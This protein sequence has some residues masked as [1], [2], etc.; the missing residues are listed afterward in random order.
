MKIVLLLFLMLISAIVLYS[1]TAIVSSGDAFLRGKPSETGEVVDTLARDAKVQIITK[2]GPWYLVQ[3]SPF[4]GWVHRSSLR[5]L[6]ST[7]KPAQIIRQKSKSGPAAQTPIVAASSSPQ[8][9]VTPSPPAETS[10][11]SS[12]TKTA[13]VTG[14]ANDGRVYIRG[15]LGGCYFMRSGGKKVY[16]DRGFCN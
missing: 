14:P 12:A 5:F 9:V 4:V 8:P 16:V 11:T 15:K 2:K 6:R 10:D 13:P 3:A 7:S 1:Q